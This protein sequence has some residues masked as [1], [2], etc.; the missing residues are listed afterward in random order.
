[1]NRRTFILSCSSG[2]LAQVLWEIN[3]A[4]GQIGLAPGLWT[5]PMGFGPSQTTQFLAKTGIL[6][7]QPFGYQTTQIVAKSG[8]LAPVTYD[9]RTTQIVVKSA[10]LVPSSYD[11]RTTQLVIKVAVR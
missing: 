4:Y 3:P 6:C 1:M 8:L 5:G 9:Q 7:S 11:Q 10:A 2:L